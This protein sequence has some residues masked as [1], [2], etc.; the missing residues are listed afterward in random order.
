MSQDHVL[1]A[2]IEQ[3]GRA[4][5]TSKRAVRF[6]VHVLRTKRDAAPFQHVSDNSKIRERRAEDD[7][8]MIGDAKAIYDPFG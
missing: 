5:L 6:R 1:A 8:H 7:R 2:E 4:H 3:H